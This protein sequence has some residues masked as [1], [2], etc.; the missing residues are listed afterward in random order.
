VWGEVPSR[1]LLREGEVPSRFLLR[2]G[3]AGRL[4]Q[5]ES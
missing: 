1:F 3:E 5:E 2:E 4:A